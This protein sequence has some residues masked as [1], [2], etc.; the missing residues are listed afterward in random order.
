MLSMFLR[1]QSSCGAPPPTGTSVASRS[2]IVWTDAKWADDGTGAM[3]IG[4]GDMTSSVWVS[5]LTGDLRLLVA[6]S[7]VFDE[8]SQPVKTGALRLSFKPPLWGE[9]VDHC[10]KNVPGTASYRRY[11]NAT[12]SVICDQG[13]QITIPS[14]K[15]C[16]AA[17]DAC[18]EAAA[19]ACCADPRCVAFSFNGGWEHG[20]LPEFCSSP[21]MPDS[22]GEGW[23][24]W[25][26]NDIPAPSMAFQ[27][28]LDLATSTVTISTP[29]VD[30]NVFIDLNAPHRDGKPHRDAG[31]LHVTAT[32]KA[33]QPPFDLTATLEP[34]RQENAVTQLGRG[35]C[36]PRYEHA[37]TVVHT[38]VHTATT[39]DDEV[40]WYHWNHINTSYYNDTIQ[41]QGLDPETYAGTLVD[42][43][44]HLAFG[45]KFSASGLKKKSDTQLFGASLNSV[46]V[47]VTLLTLPGVEDPQTWVTEIDKIVPASPPSSSYSYRD[48]PEVFTTWDALWDRSF[49]ELNNSTTTTRIGDDDDDDDD[50]D[51][52]KINDHVNWDRYLSLIQGRVSFAPIKFNGQAFTCNNTG[53][54]WDY[55]SWGADYWWQNERQP[56]YNTIAAGDLDTLKAFLDFYLRMLPYVEARTKVQFNGTITAGAFYE[57]TTTQFGMYNQ[58]DWGCNSPIPRP[59]SA[60]SNK[61]IR[62]HYTGGLELSLMILDYWDATQDA[63]DLERYFPIAAAVVEAYRQRFPNKNSTTGKIDMFPNQA[64]ETSQVSWAQMLPHFFVVVF[65]GCC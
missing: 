45:G 2:N 55:R 10:K 60:S 49:I 62:F 5:S 65:C 47:A 22:P 7:D 31:I 9:P 38:V 61:Y 42:P 59:Q 34:Y 4:N 17:G 26:V 58:G 36:H 64:L 54:G 11:G 16:A 46:D 28:T 32:S 33:G 37:D 14:V 19:E 12:H 43:F 25:I 15:S 53:K 35:F 27:Q 8:N 21:T 13:A 40:K 1:V 39:D 24:T 30:V 52:R 41:N 44:T 20:L 56:Y 18:V 6:K 23:Q 29:S 48:E 63:T 57:E 51:V 3:P 50:D